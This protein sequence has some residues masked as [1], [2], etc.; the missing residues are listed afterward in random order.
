VTSFLFRIP[1]IV[2]AMKAAQPEIGIRMMM[3]AAVFVSR[4]RRAIALERIDSA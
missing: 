1:V 2:A 4:N 3:G